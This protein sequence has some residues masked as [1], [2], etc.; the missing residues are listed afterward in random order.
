M[1]QELKNSVKAPAVRFVN[2]SE[3][4]FARLLDYYHIEWQYEPRSF[5]LQWDSEGRVLEAFTPD[6]YLPEQDLYVEL[7]TM[8]QSLANR[9]NRKLR[10][11]QE[12]YPEI[13][14][15]LLYRGDYQS[16]LAKYGLASDGPEQEQ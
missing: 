8:K 6:F 5:P 15:K 16:L 14:I 7:T 1:N 9:K 12:L 4:E 3:E 11:L 2:S 10:R 13:H